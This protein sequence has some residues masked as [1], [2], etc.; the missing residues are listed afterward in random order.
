VGDAETSAG[1]DPRVADPAADAAVDPGSTPSPAPAVAPDGPH[2]SMAHT[3]GT[4]VVATAG[5]SGA[6][7]PP[8]AFP[9]AS[10][11]SAEVSATG[12]PADWFLD[13]VTLEPFGGE[14][15]PDG[16]L[17]ERLE[18]W[19]PSLAEGAA[20]PERGGAA[21]GGGVARGGK[22][23]KRGIKG[24]MGRVR[25]PAAVAT[26][27][28]E[29]LDAYAATASY[30]PRSSVFRPGERWATIR[31]EALYILQERLLANHFPEAPARAETAPPPPVPTH[32][33][34][35]ALYNRYLLARLLTLRQKN[36]LVHQAVHCSQR[37]P[38]ATAQACLARS[39][40]HF[41]KTAQALYHTVL[42][43]QAASAD[44]TALTARVAAAAPLPALCTRPPRPAAR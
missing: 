33:E 14:E 35:P 26:R 19:H 24:V 36:V 32:G 11:P 34:Y 38:Y 18:Y 16:D 9:T 44:L 42:S 3:I 7:S 13:P 37:R 4:H 41:E 29:E 21:G 23:L 31:M 8:T 6:L 22:L 28:R 12:P 1:P 20:N 43:L 40:G 10:S 39:T 30:V 5:V 27:L 17:T 25:L 2:A 15:E